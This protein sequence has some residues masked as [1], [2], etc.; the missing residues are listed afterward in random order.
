MT[1][2]VT[3]ILAQAYGLIAS[4]AKRLQDLLAVMEE[5]SL[6]GCVVTIYKGVL[7]CTLFQVLL[8]LKFGMYK[9]YL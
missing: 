8:K 9:I 2:F 1:S 6:K 7:P 4:Q 5:H 3:Y